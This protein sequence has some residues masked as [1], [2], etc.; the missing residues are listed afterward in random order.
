MTDDLCSTE[1]GAIRTCSPNTAAAPIRILRISRQPASCQLGMRFAPP[2]WQYTRYDGI[3][4][5]STCDPD[6]GQGGYAAPPFREFYGKEVGPTTTKND[7]MQMQDNLYG[8][9]GRPWRRRHLPGAPPTEGLNLDN[10]RTE[11]TGADHGHPACSLGKRSATIF[12]SA[13]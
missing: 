10:A 13:R 2:H 11:R 12:L 9:D 1:A 7:I 8:G 6:N 5:D 4:R 3:N